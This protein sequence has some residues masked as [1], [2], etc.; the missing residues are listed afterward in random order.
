[1]AVGVLK[2]LMINHTPMKT[3]QRPPGTAWIELRWKPRTC[4]TDPIR[5]TA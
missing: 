1:M 5:R 4:S 2:P 3:S